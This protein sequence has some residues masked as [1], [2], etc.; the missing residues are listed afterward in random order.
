MV[1]Q[2]SPSISFAEGRV[3]QIE[4]LRDLTS[5]DSEYFERAWHNE[6]RQVLLAG[7]GASYAALA[8]PLRRMR[9]TGLAVTRSDCSDLP[10]VPS[11]SPDVLIALSQ[12]GRSVETT[13]LASSFAAEGVPTLS[14]TNAVESP[15]GR[16]STENITLG[17]YPDSRV[18]SVGFVTTFTALAMLADIAAEGHVSE[19]WRALPDLIENTMA[20][21]APILTEFAHEHLAGG[22]V[23]VVAAAAQ[24]TTA[25]AVAL[26]FREGPLV[27]SSAFGTRGYLHGPMDIA[28]GKLT[29]V[30]IGG[31]R[32]RQLAEQLAEQTSAILL[33]T[34]DPAP[35]HRG[36][37]VRVPPEMRASERALLEVCILQELV[38]AAANARGNPVDDSVFT[39]QDTKLQV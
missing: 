3:S 22:S 39:R 28:G 34:D 8:T 36:I 18:S 37:V 29:H 20:T 11:P 23:D 10:T 7:I 25:E 35:L 27:P 33:L 1:K 2:V 16:T 19:S 12:S 6:W 31:A 30:L 17:G 13:E 38:Q 4:A 9:S 26:L 21:A 14:I 24:L 15:L 5:R 32:E